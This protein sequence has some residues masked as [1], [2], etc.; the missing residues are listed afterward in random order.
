MSR[1]ELPNNATCTNCGKEFHLKPYKLAHV[2]GKC[3]T[4][5]SRQCFAEYKKIWFVGEN[6]HQFGLSGSKN[7]SFKGKEIKKRNNTEVD[8]WVYVPEHK[9]ANQAG[10]VK[11]HRLVVEQN[12]SLFDEKY[13]EVENG[14][15]FLKP[16]IEV[17]HKDLNHDNND[18]T[19]LEPLTKSEHVSLHN[20]MNQIIRD[21]KGR[22]V[23]IIK[24]KTPNNTT[25]TLNEY[26]QKALETAVYPEQYR[27][28]YPALGLNGEA[29]EVADKVK[30]VIRDNEASFEDD[31]RKQALALELG[32][33]LW[34]IA[35]LANDLGFSLED[36]GE[37][38]YA[39]LKSRQERGK[40]GGSGDNR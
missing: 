35:T 18:I 31:E 40:L 6:N 17:H 23:T 12:Y 29:G 22:I 5:C 21:D 16:E 4:F 7:A 25:M 20:K 3:G 27:I 34:Y 9:Y 11:K 39:K 24:R 33:V 36:I 8:V 13:F 15:H 10:R 30:K 14:K 28:I 32:D 26:Q 2:T 37:M 1:R 38:N 19:N